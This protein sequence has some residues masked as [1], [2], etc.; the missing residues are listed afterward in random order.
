MTVSVLIPSYNHAPF[1][2]R[3]LRSV[4]KQTL[5]PIKLIVIDDGSK[6]DSVKII[7][8]ALQDCPFD[9]QLIM[10]ENRGLCATLNEGLLLTDSKYFAYIGSDDVWLPSFLEN[11]IKLLENHTNSC[12]AYGHA[13]LINENDEIIDLTEKWSDYSNG[14]TLE[15]LLYSDKCEHRLP[16]RNSEKISV[17]QRCDFGRLRTVFTACGK[18]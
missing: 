7:E 11:R 16:N 9:S 2:E 17:E 6:D 18:V 5:P 13:F 1:V 8:K 14:K 15:M 12:L 4:F 3:T 10:R